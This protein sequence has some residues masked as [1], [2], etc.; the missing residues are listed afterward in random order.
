M[1]NLPPSGIRAP[2][3][4]GLACISVGA[5]PTPST[6]NTAAFGPRARHFRARVSRT[7]DRRARRA[8]PASGSGPHRTA[9]RAPCPCRASRRGTPRR[10]AGRSSAA[11]PSS[12][13]LHPGLGELA[14]L[15]VAVRAERRADHTHVSL[16]LLD[17][18]RTPACCRRRRRCAASDAR[19]TTG[20]ASFSTR[21]CDRAARLRGERHADQPAHRGADPAHRLDVEARD[22]RHHVGDVLRHAVEHRVGEPVGVAAAGDVGADHAKAAAQRARQVVEVAPV[23]RQAVHADHHVAVA[24]VAPL[25]VGHAVQALG[26]GAL[27]RAASR[28]L[29]YARFSHFSISLSRASRPSGSSE[30]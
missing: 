21:R 27:H 5:W 4:S 3:R 30:E 28:R 18:R 20:P 24:R 23:A 26:R 10:C 17:G 22:Q 14:P 29:G 12:L 16:G 7:G 6:S 8:A 2:A 15:R 11:S 19:L 1:L 13:F 25:Q 9:A